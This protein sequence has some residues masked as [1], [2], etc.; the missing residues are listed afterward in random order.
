MSEGHVSY[1]VY[2]K[3][4]VIINITGGLSVSMSVQ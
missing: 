1:E 4:M 2:I 3:W